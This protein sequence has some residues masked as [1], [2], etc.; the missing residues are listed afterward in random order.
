MP[1]LVERKLR[2]S[3]PQLTFYDKHLALIEMFFIVFL[4]WDALSFC[5]P[6]LL[7]FFP[8]QIDRRQGSVPGAARANV[9]VTV[10]KVL[11]L[12]QLRIWGEPPRYA[13]VWKTPMSSPEECAP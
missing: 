5:S 12:R 6:L 1:L 7:F 9:N 3:E 2:F 13:V 11:S 10:L 4:S 8:L